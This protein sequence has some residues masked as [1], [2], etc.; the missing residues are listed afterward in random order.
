MRRD[1]AALLTVKAV[2]NLGL[3]MS[4]V[5]VHGKVWGL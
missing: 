1:E 4:A 2:A 5:A 3:G